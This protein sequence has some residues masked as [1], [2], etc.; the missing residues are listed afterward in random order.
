M[1]PA[2]PP[3]ASSRPLD[4]IPPF[5]TKSAPRH[6]P[7]FDA[8]RG[9]AILAVLVVHAKIPLRQPLPP[10]ISMSLGFGEHGVQLFYLRL[11]PRR[12]LRRQIRARP[13]PPPIPQRPHLP[14]RPIPLSLAPQPTPRLRPWL[15]TLL[16]RQRPPR[17]SQHPRRPGPSHLLRKTRLP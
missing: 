4:P 5:T 9:Y 17:Q 11:R 3:P 13:R 1:N 2:L 14:P 15:R 7:V 6:I 8:L 12:L 16:P 10:K